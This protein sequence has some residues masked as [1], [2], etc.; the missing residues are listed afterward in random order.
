MKKKWMKIVALMMVACL[1][2]TTAGC[3]NN[4]DQQ[5]QQP[6]ES[7][8]PAEET[9]EA[10]ESETESIEQ[11]TT[12]EM[13]YVGEIK[14]GV[15]FA[16][17]G[18]SN[19]TGINYIQGITEV[20]NMVN[21]NGGV[22]GYKLVLETTDSSDDTDTA[23]NAI[24][25]MMEKD[26]SVIIGPHWSSQVYSVRDIIEEAGKIPVIV[27]GTNYKLPSEDYEW[28]FLGRTND[29]IQAGAMAGYICENIDCEKVGILYSSDDFG[30]GGYEVAA[31]IF[32]AN[33]IP[34]EAEAHNT[35]DTDFSSTL[36]KMQNA[37]CDVLLLWTGENPMSIFVRQIEEYGMHDSMQIFTSPGMA[38]SVV[39]EA[40]DHSYLNGYY[41][42]QET[43]YDESNSEIVDY[44]A[45]YN[46]EYGVN[47]DNAAR[48]YANIMQCVVDALERAEDPT[49][50]VSVRDAL[51]ATQNTKTMFGN[52][53]C[54][55]FHMLNHS[56]TLAQFNSEIDDLEFVQLI[57]N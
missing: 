6:A 55:E 56:I 29:S 3:G 47:P 25:L 44:Y 20:T 48:A 38:G 30:Q 19:S 45:A 35:T 23:M 28:M 34:Y 1:G 9:E 17:T 42:V 53:T 31:G 16:I 54:D 15:T 2:I 13:E 11:G 7:Q 21:A 10:A 27:G 36:L 26:Y 41:S 49:D 32:E 37:G 14:I 4:Q 18:A 24:N 57:E 39:L 33:N 43:L 40:V 12:E 50:P 22:N 8:Q 5:T 51:E 46:E 52:Y